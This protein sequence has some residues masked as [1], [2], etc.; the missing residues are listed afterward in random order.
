[1]MAGPRSENRQNEADL[2]LPIYDEAQHRERQNAKDQIPSD[3]GNN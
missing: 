1:M 3:C 2:M